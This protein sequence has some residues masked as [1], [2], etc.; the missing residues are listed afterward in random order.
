LAS[1]GSSDNLDIT[2]NPYQGLKLN[3]AAAT[4]GEGRKLDITLNPYQGLK[5]I[6]SSNE[7]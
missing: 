1:C 3:P 7:R 5:R 6:M 2:L 4:D